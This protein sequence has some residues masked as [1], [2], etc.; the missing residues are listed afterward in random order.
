MVACV[1][2]IGREAA[3]AE[4]GSGGGAARIPIDSVCTA[5]IIQSLLVCVALA[6]FMLRYSRRPLNLPKSGPMSTI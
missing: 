5:I 2:G 6:P 1:M 3:D 4:R